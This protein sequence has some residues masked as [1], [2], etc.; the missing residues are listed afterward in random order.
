M[1][2]CMGD[3]GMTDC[4]DV[5]DRPLSKN[6]VAAHVSWSESTGQGV[7]RCYVYLTSRETLPYALKTGDDSQQCMCLAISRM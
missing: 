4:R 7:H 6:I 5:W 2:G 1:R 3:V